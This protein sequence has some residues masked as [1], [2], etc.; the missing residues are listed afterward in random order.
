MTEWFRGY[1]KRKVQT[2]DGFEYK[3]LLI[4]YGQEV[5]VKSNRLKQL[6]FEFSIERL[7]SQLLRI[8]LFGIMP[9]FLEISIT[10]Q[11]SKF[12]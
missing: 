11:E 10:A 6:P 8:I 1:V 3:I 9:T 4:D 2:I 5:K 12:R 7:E